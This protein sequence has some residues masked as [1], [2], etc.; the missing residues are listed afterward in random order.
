MKIC[1]ACERELPDGSYSEEQRRLRQSMRRCEECVAAGNQLVLMKKGHTRSESD[2]CPIC[3]LPLPI[4]AKHWK[5]YV[6]CMKRLCTGC[7]LAAGKRGMWGCPFCRAASP[8]ESQALA[9]IRKRVGAGDPLAIWHL[10]TKYILGAYGLEKDVT[11]AVELY[12]R[13]ADLGVKE[14][15]YNL[16]VLYDE[17]IEV[18]KDIDK[19]IGHYETAAMY[20]CEDSLDNIKELFM[21][22]LAT[23]DDY[24]SALRGHQHAIE[25]LS[26]PDRGEAKI[27]DLISSMGVAPRLRHPCPEDAPSPPRS[28]ALLVPPAALLGRPPEPAVGGRGALRDDIRAERRGR[29]GRGT[30]QPSGTAAAGL[31]HGGPSTGPARE[32]RRHISVRSDRTLP[33]SMS[34]PPSDRAAGGADWGG[35]GAVKSVRIPRRRSGTGRGRPEGTTRRELPRLAAR[36]PRCRG[37]SRPTPRVL[38]PRVEWVPAIAASP[39]L[40]G[41]RRLGPRRPTAG[42]WWPAVEVGR[43]AEVVP[44]EV[45]A[46]RELDSLPPATCP[47]FSNAGDQLKLLGRHWVRAPPRLESRDAPRQSSLRARNPPPPPRSVSSLR[48][49]QIQSPTSKYDPVPLVTEFKHIVGVSAP[50]G[51]TTARARPQRQLHTLFT[52]TPV[53]G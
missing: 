39:P 11:R 3:Q 52:D 44:A 38:R 21:S 49:V 32:Y 15:H 26:S 31:P 46:P 16:G 48:E 37:R 4:D 23:K 40:L 29:A 14:A 19:A 9:M 17:G 5:F 6:C 50:P 25:E 2:D 53:T 51:L 10:G 42:S 1:G 22:G 34:G 18:A 41:D 47:A 7:V 33:P 30:R 28:E 24:A 27:F 8:D 35:G 36:R 13:A 12:E 20:G 45:P 43:Q